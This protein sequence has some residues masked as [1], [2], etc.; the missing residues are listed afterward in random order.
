[1][2]RRA[3]S[4][5]PLQL[6]VQSVNASV[7]RQP[8]ART[9]SAEYEDKQQSIL[10]GAARLFAERGFP[11]TT[12]EALARS[13]NASKAWIY[14]YY[15]SKEAVLYALLKDHVLRL[16]ETAKDA[17]SWDVDPKD[18]LRRL[19]RSMLGVYVDATAKHVVLMNEI[20]ALPPHQRDELQSLQNELVDIF[21]AVIHEIRPE[22]EASPQHRRPVAMTL[23]GMINWTY[24]WFRPTGPLSA[25]QF[26]D[27]VTDLFLGGVMNIRIN[28]EN[29]T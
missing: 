20:D 19:V 17:V 22:L 23:M 8:M 29:E 3:L 26:A 16:I 9:R 14:H 10:D 15:D 25:P 11:K 13:L 21:Q 18:K 24:T 28:E 1:M 4:G 27:M 6:T 12:I 7:P 2:T 5:S